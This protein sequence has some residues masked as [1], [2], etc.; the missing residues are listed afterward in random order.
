MVMDEQV[1][2]LQCLIPQAAHAA[3]FAL[4]FASV[5]PHLFLSSWIQGSF[6]LEIGKKE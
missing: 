4:Q 3:F 5:M 1:K 6:L 2:V